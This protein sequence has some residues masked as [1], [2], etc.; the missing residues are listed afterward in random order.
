MPVR[1]V[2]VH[3]DAIFSDKLVTALISAGHQVAAFRDPLEAWGA[4]EAARLTEVL[5][6]RIQF[7]PGR[8]NGLALA[9]MVRSKRPNIQIIFIA[10]PEFAEECKE[11]GVF[12]PRAVAV[13]DVVETVELLLNRP[14]NSS[15]DGADFP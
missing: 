9:Y 2:L 13:P 11:I 8:S 14:R 15:G 5:I 1:V 10:L 3:D 6:T 7:P 4:L 12:L